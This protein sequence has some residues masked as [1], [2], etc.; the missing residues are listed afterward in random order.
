MSKK[1]ITLIIALIILGVAGLVK[2][3]LDDA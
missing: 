2:A 1:L 3:I